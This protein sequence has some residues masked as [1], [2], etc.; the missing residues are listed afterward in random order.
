MCATA[1]YER[2]QQ[3]PQ[4][5]FHCDL[6]KC[7]TP[8]DQCWLGGDFLKARHSAAGEDL[9]PH[10]VR[11]GGGGGNQNNNDNNNGNSNSNSNDNSSQNSTT[12]GSNN[13]YTYNDNFSLDTSGLKDFFN[14]Y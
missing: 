5:S 4:N 6:L 11:S 10:T 9:N 3:S 12:N 8:P 2:G 7:K 1:H 14:G 13:R